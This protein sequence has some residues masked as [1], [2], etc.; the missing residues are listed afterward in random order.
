MKNHL[1][2]IRHFFSSS[3][4][5]LTVL[6]LITSCYHQKPETHDAMVTYSA[7]QIDSLSFQAKHHYTNNYNFIVK[8]DSMPLIRQQPEADIIGYCCL[9][10]HGLCHSKT[11]AQECPF[12]AFSRYRL[13]LSNIVGYHCGFCS[14]FLCQHSEL[15]PRCVET[16]LFPPYA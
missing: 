7:K 2:H 14:D 12:G 1:R 3:I 6:L 4:C 9:D 10:F 13:V 5:V 15:C 8:A 11:H 16:F